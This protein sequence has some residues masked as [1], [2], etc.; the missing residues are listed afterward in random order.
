MSAP[1]THAPSSAP[2]APAAAAPSRAGLALLKPGQGAA[3]RW[4]AYLFLGV[5]L[6]FG[7]RSLFGLLY[8]ESAEALVAGLPLVGDITWAKVTCALVFVFGALAIHKVL[9]RASLVDLLIDTEQELK[10]VSWPSG[11]DVKG[12]TMV[13]SLVTIVMGAILFWADELLMLLF[14][15]IF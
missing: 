3:S 10:K 12:A 9:N 14:R 4:L 2:A 5:L 7:V 11:S 8:R 1:E 13:V 15:F 6:A